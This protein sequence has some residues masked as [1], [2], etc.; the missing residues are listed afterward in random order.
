MKIDLIAY[1]KTYQDFIDSY[2]EGDEKIK[3]I[4]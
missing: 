2:Q 1:L 3:E 4:P